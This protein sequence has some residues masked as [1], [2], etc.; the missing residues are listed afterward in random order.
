MPQDGGQVQSHSHHRRHPP[1]YQHVSIVSFSS[2]LNSL[3]CLPRSRPG[4]S[5]RPYVLQT[6]FP[7]KV[8]SDDS[9]TLSDASLLNSVV[10]QKYT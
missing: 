10:A 2:F 5:A 9:Q 4:E 7:V 3:D 1:L 6:T 8:L